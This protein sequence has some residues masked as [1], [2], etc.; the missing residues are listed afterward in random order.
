[1]LLALLLIALAFPVK[2]VDKDLLLY[3][4]F[5]EEGKVAKDETGKTNGGTIFDVITWVEGKFGKALELDGKGGY[6]EIE[7]TPEL[8]FT[9][10]SSFTL[11]IWMKSEHATSN[12]KGIFGT[13]G[14]TKPSC[15]FGLYHLE[16]G[17]KSNLL[18]TV[19]GANIEDTQKGRVNDGE[20]HHLA[21][22][23]D[24]KAGVIKF[25][26][27]TKLIG[28]TNDP[29]NNPDNGQ[30]KAWLGNHLNRW[31]TVTLDEARIWGRALSENEIARLMK[32]N[33]MAVTL[34]DKLAT[35]WSTIKFR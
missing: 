16:D 3:L 10:E 7:L 28:E 23:R 33:V 19:P 4:S 5:D 15:H 34:R 35:T 12:N 6:V 27:D 25:Y 29:G 2:A 1:M 14:P 20:W 13:Y 11:E 18:F 31:W 22:V 17:G 24:R 21:G 8:I 26:V 9:E 30:G 32:N